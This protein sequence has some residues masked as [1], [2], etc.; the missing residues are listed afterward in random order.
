MEQSD[1]G[2]GRTCRPHEED[3]YSSPSHYEKRKKGRSLDRS[4]LLDYSLAPRRN[5]IVVSFKFVPFGLKFGLRLL[6]VNG[7]RNKSRFR[8]TKS[9]IG[10]RSLKEIVMPTLLFKLLGVVF[11]IMLGKVRTKICSCL[12]L[13]PK[14]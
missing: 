14:N 11:L 8:Q 2:R 6:S 12:F 9:S 5:N 4:S 7:I 10:K 3:I 1:F 13:V